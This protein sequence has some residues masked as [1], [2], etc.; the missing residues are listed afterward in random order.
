MIENNQN[1]NI[2]GE[3]LSANGNENVN[4]NGVDTVVSSEDQNANVG[5]DS[6]MSAFEV[7]E[8]KNDNPTN[9]DLAAGNG[10]EMNQLPEYELKYRKLQ[11]EY[12]KLFHR[13]E[14]V[15]REYEE[16]LKAKEFVND[17]LEDEEVFEAF[18]YERKPEL[19]SHKD[20]TEAM[21]EKLEKEFG[22][23]KP[24]SR[25]DTSPK[26]YLYF[27]R[28]DEMYEEM[29]NK[30]SVPKTLSELK[31]QREKEKELNKRKIQEE[32][33]K[34]KKVMNWDDSQLENFQKWANSLKVT[35]LMKMYNFALKTNRLSPRSSV[36]SSQGSYIGKS[37]RDNFLRSLK[38]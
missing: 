35:D 37:A 18:V 14:Q 12:D 7:E 25:E 19:I 24:E 31:K 26:A 29:K 4:A 17:L 27:K 22:D 13:N 1:V 21:Q 15:V 10:S 28:L 2:D 9:D 16:A 8:G 36:A 32:I 5:A 20:L 30:K 34:A 33:S 23:Y 6:L 3:G 11:S 38:Y